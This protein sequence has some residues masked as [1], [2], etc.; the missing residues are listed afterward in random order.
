M[1]QLLVAYTTKSGGPAT[2]YQLFETLNPPDSSSGVPHQ[3]HALYPTAAQ[4]PG[5]HSPILS[6]ASPKATSN[7][8]LIPMHYL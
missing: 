1:H 8:Y 7:T 2:M 5:N 6:E 4:N 3:D